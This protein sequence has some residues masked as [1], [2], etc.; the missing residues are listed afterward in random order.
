[1][2]AYLSGSI[3]V[4]A[5]KAQ[6]WILNCAI[7]P[8]YIVICE[9]AVDLSLGIIMLHQTKHYIEWSLQLST[10]VL[11]NSCKSWNQ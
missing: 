3:I 8:T 11:Y 6:R 1:M 7:Y 10:S 2:R 9:S 5:C 4:H